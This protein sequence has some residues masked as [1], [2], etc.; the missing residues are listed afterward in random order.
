MLF[1]HKS[2]I[3][4]NFVL[5]KKIVTNAEKMTLREIENLVNRFQSC[6]I[7]QNSLINE[8]LFK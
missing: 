1:E 4:L 7:L 8:L 3:L 6:L 5:Q 2:Q